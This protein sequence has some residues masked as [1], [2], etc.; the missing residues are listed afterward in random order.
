[1]QALGAPCKI[2]KCLIIQKVTTIFLFH[3][4]HQSLTRLFWDHTEWMVPRSFIWIP[5]MFVSQGPTPAAR[6]SGWTRS[7]PGEPCLS[8]ASW[9]VLLYLASISC[10][11]AGRG[12]N[13]FGS[14]CRNPATQKITCL[15]GCHIIL[16]FCLA[17]SVGSTVDLSVSYA[18]N[19]WAVELHLTS[20]KFS[21]MEC[22]QKSIMW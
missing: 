8:A 11:K 4:A 20:L 17:F 12:V 15:S 2:K 7:W 1:V 18:S 10:N 6:P 3:H 5:D 13:G 16:G 22:R 19:G 9:L 14:F 21:M